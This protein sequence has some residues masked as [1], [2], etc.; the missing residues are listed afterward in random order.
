MKK[1]RNWLAALLLGLILAFGLVVRL[2]D[3]T[4]PPFDFNPTRQLRSAIIARGL[5]YQASPEAD[6]ETRQLAIEHWSGMERLEPL[7]FENLVAF[8][9]RLMGREAL[10][11][12]RVFA[13]AFWLLG[14]AALF[15]LGRRMASPWAAL[16][17]L[18]F[19]LFMPFSIRA[20]R[21]FQPDPAM[22]M[23]ILFTAWAMYRWLEQP[24]WKWAI[25]AGVFGGMA[26]YTKIA[27]AFFV[28][29][30]A[31]GAVLYWIQ[32]Q[33]APRK[34]LTAFKNPQIGV[35]AA[36]M[37]LPP[38]IYY[39]QGRE[40]ASGY[41]TT[42]TVIKRWR[43][44][45]DASFYMRWLVWVDN[46]MMLALVFLGLAG[47][48]VAESKNRVLLWGLW[49]AYLAFGLT[50]P[51]HTV[52]HDY[53]HLPLIAIVGLSLVSAADLAVQKLTSQKGFIRAG[54]ALVVAVFFFYNGWI[55]RSV[56]V[57]QDYRTDPKLWRHIGQL[58][59]ADAKVI[60]LTQDYGFRLMY[61]GWKK[62]ALWPQGAGPGDFEAKIDAAQYFLITA[63]NQLNPA[64]GQYLEENFPVHADGIGYR[65]YDLRSINP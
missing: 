11:V 25:V 64:L 47:T 46:L 43:D 38:L 33:S 61:Y 22:V 28:G 60:G 9:Y 10:W 23:W 27:G 29:G 50:F 53:Y 21:S 20:S 8:T 57:A 7:I 14:G 18:S 45:L 42:W 55:G 49:A 48:F 15:D 3:I 32:A 19:Y 51:H 44:L 30:L 58:V 36:L 31:V 12:A 1:P 41:F 37:I 40:L 26:A 6:P 63:K 65:V 62:I 5:Y 2:I 34:W 24:T 39:L 17:G 56:L 59:P 13:A 35:I 4:D 16:I 52:T 54:F